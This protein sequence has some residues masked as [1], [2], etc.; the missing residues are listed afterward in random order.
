MAALVKEVKEE[1]QVVSSS[2]AQVV[3]WWGYSLQLFLSVGE[4]Y[5]NLPQVI[6]C[7]ER[8]LSVIIEGRPPLCFRCHRER[9]VQRFCN[10]RTARNEEAHK[11]PQEEQREEVGI[12][13]AD[14]KREVG[15]KLP[16]KKETEKEE[17][18]GAGRGR[19]RRS[20]F[21]EGNW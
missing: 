1:Y 3:N 16:K 7:V 12:E 11:L 13:R 19:G 20:G 10:E 2:T 4:D 5:K 18:R 14:R 17:I 21:R 15:E 8:N 6:V 9:H